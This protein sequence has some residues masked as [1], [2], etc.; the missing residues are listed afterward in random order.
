MRMTEQEGIVGRIAKRS[1][2][3]TLERL[4][5]MV[6]DGK[7]N[8]ENRRNIIYFN[9]K[10]LSCSSTKGQDEHYMEVPSSQEPTDSSIITSLGKER[11]TQQSML[12][13]DKTINYKISC[14]KLKF[15]FNPQ[16]GLSS[17]GNKG[18]MGTLEVHM[19]IH[20]YNLYFIY[21]ITKRGEHKEEWC[22]TLFN[23]DL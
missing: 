18:R 6:L 8:R 12:D 16:F 22:F 17:K 20:T 13:R 5:D 23:E 21:C 3:V 7:E 1:S 11:K 10:S 2:E 14:L 15:G 4:E 19:Q 9:G